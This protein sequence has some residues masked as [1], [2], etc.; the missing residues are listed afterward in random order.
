MAKEIAELDFDCTN[1]SIVDDNIEME[2]QQAKCCRDRFIELSFHLTR[3]FDETKLAIVKK[4]FSSLL[5]DLFYIQESCKKEEWS[6]LQ[7]YRKLFISMMLHTRD[8]VAGKGECELF[9]GLVSEWAH[10]MKCNKSKPFVT[11]KLHR[12]ME[13][14]LQQI[15][16]K[17]VFLSENEHPYGSWKDIKY[18]LEYLRDVFG[19]EEAQKLDI[20]NHLITISVVQ[21]KKDI[22]SLDNN[23]NHIS[24]VGK[25]APR[26]KS[27]RFGWLAKYFAKYYV[28]DCK[29]N[30]HANSSSIKK[31]RLRIYRKDIARLNKRLRTVQV[32]QCKK[33]WKSIDFY[34]VTSKTLMRQHN[35]FLYQTELGNACGDD[36]DR[37]ECKKNYENYI[38]ARESALKVRKRS[39]FEKKVSNNSSASSNNIS[40]EEIISRVR[41]NILHS[42]NN[43]TDKENVLNLLWA[44]SSHSMNIFKNC[45]ALVDTS[46]SMEEEDKYGHVPLDGAIGL[47]LRIAE[48]SSLGRRLLLFNSK[49]T[50]LN[51]DGC[52]KLTEMVE[53]IESDDTF[54][55]N[56]NLYASMELIAE[57]CRERDYA[58]QDIKNLTLVVLT[59]MGID[60]YSNSD[61]TCHDEIKAIF[62]KA[63]L[64]SS[65][66]QEY[67]TPHIVYWNMR[68]GLNKYGKL[69][70]LPALYTSKNVSY[71]SGFSESLLSNIAKRGFTALETCTPWS[72]L[73]KQLSHARYNWAHKAVDYAFT[74]ES[75]DTSKVNVNPSQGWWW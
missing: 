75:P 12:A 15:V 54:G 65:H 45:I 47:G 49:P 20:W 19:I 27:P 23:N 58:P 69:P 25:W 36:K 18:C 3:S 67:P 57:A 1:M 62:K 59:D 51:L 7:R 48:G 24:F 13:V 41:K 4:L 73:L 46:G 26:E 42:K 56:S 52:A 68:T 60:T 43:S 29:I 21:I 17:L 32:I 14:L 9:Y 11:K 64:E 5:N 63:G 10:V 71:L 22:Q 70:P 44:S 31:Q 34:N 8:I 61:K 35:A 55:L 6:S 53:K 50:W 72:V 40:I 39:T 28:N 2:I 33:I 37:I 16:E 66:M 74:T 30:V 38:K